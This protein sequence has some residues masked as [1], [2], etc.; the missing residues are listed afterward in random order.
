MNQRKLL[1]SLI[2]I[3]LTISAGIAGYLIGSPAQSHITQATIL[4]KFDNSITPSLSEELTKKRRLIPI[5]Q[6]LAISPTNSNSKNKVLY[7][8]KTIGRVFETAI[9]GRGEATISET[10]L[11]NFI[12]TLWSSDKQQVISQFRTPQGLQFRYYNYETKKSAAFAQNIRSIAFSPDSQEV[13][14]FQ[15][16]GELGS[17]YLALPDGSDPKKILDTRIPEIKLEWPSAQEIIAQTNQNSTSDILIISPEGGITRVLTEQKGLRHSWSPSGNNLVFSSTDQG[18]TTLQFMN[19][20]T[21]NQGT[22][23]LDTT[24]D[25]CIWSTDER[26]IICAVPKS[27]IASEDFFRFDIITGKQELLFASDSSN[28]PIS[29]QEPFLSQ[30]EGYLIFLNNID[31]RLYSLKI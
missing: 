18:T 6:Q 21:K 15:T 20:Q 28:P 27:T 13:V 26:S 3:T 11:P 16:E 17:I 19:I 23:A 9:D 29:V 10:K 31:N 25:K 4:E 5:S 1:I 2:V 12:Q 22:I 30:G 24:A 7:Y 14:Y 8:E